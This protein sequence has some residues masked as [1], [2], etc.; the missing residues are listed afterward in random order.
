MRAAWPGCR[1]VRRPTHAA[2]ARLTHAHTRAA[3]Q[4]MQERMHAHAHARMSTR[5]HD[6]SATQRNAPQGTSRRVTAPRMLRAW[7]GVGTSRACV[8]RAR[9]SGTTARGG[10]TRCR[11]Q[12]ARASTRCTRSAGPVGLQ[13]CSAGGLRRA[14]S[15]PPICRASSPR[16]RRACKRMAFSSDPNGLCPNKARPYAEREPCVCVCKRE[17]ER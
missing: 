14:S 8:R 15:A 11:S 2:A 5:E 3:Q 13:L 4:C 17:R 1:E 12:D 16:R 6:F 10:A 7:L 9:P